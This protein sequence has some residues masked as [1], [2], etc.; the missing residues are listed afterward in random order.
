MKCLNEIQDKIQ[1]L[2]RMHMRHVVYVSREI[3]DDLK[4]KK[5]NSF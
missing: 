4:S 5:K 1:Y 2:L 3:V